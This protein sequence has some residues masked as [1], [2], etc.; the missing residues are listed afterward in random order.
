MPFCLLISSTELLRLCKR[1]AV[2]TDALSPSS[3]AWQLA[4]RRHSCSTAIEKKDH[5]NEMYEFKRL[6]AAAKIGA[7]ADLNDEMF[8]NQ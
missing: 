8:E 2:K 6:F 3:A 7:A 4:A 1:V 5:S